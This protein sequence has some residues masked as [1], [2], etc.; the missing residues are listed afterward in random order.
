MNPLKAIADR[1]DRMPLLGALCCFMAG[2][3]LTTEA[4]GTALACGLVALICW[5]AYSFCRTKL[6]IGIATMG[7][8]ALVGWMNPSTEITLPQER[9]ELQVELL[10]DPVRMGDRL[11]S[12]ARLLAWR[13]TQGGEW[14]SS[15]QRINLYIDT[16]A[17]RL[18]GNDRIRMEG[19]IYPARRRAGSCYLSE[20]NLIERTPA[21]RPSLHNGATNRLKRLLGSPSDERATLLAMTV[22]ASEEISPPMRQ[23]YSQSGMAHLLA[24]SGLHTSF[25][26]L[27]INLLLWWMPLLR[28]GHRLRNLLSLLLLWG[29]VAMAG[30]APSAVRAAVMCSLLQFALYR[31]SGYVAMNSW[32]AAALLLLIVK[33]S[34]TEDIGFRLSF[35]A[36]AGI[37]VWGVPLMRRCKTRYRVVNYLVGGW[38]VALTAS[39]A[40]APFTA[41]TFHTVAWTGMVVS[42]PV[43]TLGAFIVAGGLVMLLIG[44]PF[45]LLREGLL[46][47]ARL[48][49]NTA[50]WCASISDGAIGWYPTEEDAVVCYLLFALLTMALWCWGTQK[51]V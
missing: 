11:R 36:V 13:S 19:R 28:N 4:R 6:L 40:V 50:E 42:P 43:V 45:G 8:G 24:V 33:P 26:F 14:Q 10:R 16:L 38:I 27:L 34:L 12:E 30:G 44:S 31:G 15:S 2:L 3:C 22:G 5:A 1:L 41:S 20:N 25:V 9:L 7:V 18:R 39:L 35:A 17:P 37:L 23:A 49:N 47:L 32:A 51:N 48:Q 29:Y 21:T 46:W